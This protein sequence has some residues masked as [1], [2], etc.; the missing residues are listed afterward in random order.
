MNLHKICNHIHKNIEELKANHYLLKK[1]K[2]EL[3]QVRYL[4]LQEQVKDNIES[5]LS[6]VKVQQTL[7][8]IH[9]V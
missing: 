2:K 9:L 5:N 7:Y 1:Y 6:T 4:Y 3:D 8:Y